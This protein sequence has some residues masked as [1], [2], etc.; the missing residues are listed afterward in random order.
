MGEIYVNVCKNSQG[1]NEESEITLS[2]H[3]PIFPNGMGRYQR[4]YNFVGIKSRPTRMH[5]DEA[6][7]TKSFLNHLEAP[8][9]WFLNVQPDIQHQN[10]K[11]KTCSP[12]EE[13]FYIENFL[14]K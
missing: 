10:E 6:K 2:L 14:E 8:K 12:N 3:F 13:F 7:I 4:R 1:H 11:K 5:Y 9:R